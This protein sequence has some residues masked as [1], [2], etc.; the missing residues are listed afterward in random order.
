MQMSRFIIGAHPRTK[1]PTK[2]PLYTFPHPIAFSRAPPWSS[3]PASCGLDLA[4]NQPPASLLAARFS[5]AGAI[6]Q[7]VRQ[8]ITYKLA[9]LTYKVPSTSTLV[10][11]HDQGRSQKF[12][13]GTKQGVWGTEAPS[14]VQGQSPGGGLGRSPRSWRHT[15]C[16]TVF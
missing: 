13:K 10:Y 5:P 9:V 16:I 6:H 7:Q 12:A 8:R 2:F 11:L 14:G 4:V 3:P 15:E 1:N